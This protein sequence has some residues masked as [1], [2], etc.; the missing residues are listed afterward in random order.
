MKRF[1]RKA[2]LAAMFTGVGILFQFGSCIPTALT[3]GM[4]AI[5]FCALLGDDCTLGPIAP[6]GTP[7]SPFDNLLVDCPGPLTNPP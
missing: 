7:L 3:I 5:D 1:K 2:V 6:C 4:S